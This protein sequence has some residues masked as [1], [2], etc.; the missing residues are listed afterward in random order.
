MTTTKVN[1]KIGDNDN[2]DFSMA[3]TVS[4][5]ETDYR[6]LE[7]CMNTY[8]CDEYDE[9]WCRLCDAI[10]SQVSALPYRWFVDGPVHRA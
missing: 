6:I 7:D 1:V 3:A 2:Y 5:S 8:S 10:T 4:I 9:A